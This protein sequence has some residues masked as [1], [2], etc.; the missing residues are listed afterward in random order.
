MDLSSIKHMAW[1]CWIEQA[2]IISLCLPHPVAAA[3][4]NYS[5]ELFLLQEWIFLLNT[6]YWIFYFLKTYGLFHVLLSSFQ[7]TEMLSDK[8]LLL[9]MMLLKQ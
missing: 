1:H 3:T 8:W 6:F 5:L 9:I 7:E 4:P 2:L